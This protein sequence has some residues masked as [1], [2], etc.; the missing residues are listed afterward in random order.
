MTSTVDDRMPYVNGVQQDPASVDDVAVRIPSD[1]PQDAVVAAWLAAQATNLSAGVGLI[2]Y[3]SDADIR[4]VLNSGLS[5]PPAAQPPLILPFLTEDLLA[6]TD[7]VREVHRGAALA[8]RNG[9]A[10]LAATPL[11]E[12]AL[13]GSTVSHAEPSELDASGLV[14]RSELA[15]MLE[16][17]CV[18]RVIENDATALYLTPIEARMAAALRNCRIDFQPQVAIG[19]F[20]ADFLVR[21]RRPSEPGLIVECDGAGFHE[22]ER[23]AARDAELRALGHD[24]LRF[25]GSQIYRD[26]PACAAAE[27]GRAHV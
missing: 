21:R 27:I 9:Q 8:R 5:T 15:F 14:A 25:S 18:A 11:S 3:R 13:A 6:A 17:S 20:R 4:S 12:A 26:A 24:V 7:A 22:P 19:R 1:K 2:V 23:D 16:R 10:I